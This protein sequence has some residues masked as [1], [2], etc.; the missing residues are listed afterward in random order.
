MKYPKL[1]CEEKKNTV[2]CSI[3]IKKMKKLRKEGHT[4]LH[5]SK[6]LKIS[7]YVVAYHVSSTRN[8]QEYLEKRKRYNREY[9][10]KSIKG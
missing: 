8:T 7:E 5:I 2:V 4:Y 1:K 9:N 10:R 3:D 6:V